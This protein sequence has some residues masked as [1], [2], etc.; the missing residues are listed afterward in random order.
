MVKIIIENLGQKELLLSG[1]N[2][3]A[4]Q[5][6]QSHFVD[7]MQACGG[8]GRCTTCRMIVLEG[9]D[10]LGEHTEAELHYRKAGLLL[11][12]ERLACQV[13]VK[14]SL[15]IRVPKDSKLPHIRYTD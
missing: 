13:L 15:T 5:H 9:G 11:E 14:E 3:T 4:L 1:L 2:K 6:L 10:N 8:K 7:W 12:N